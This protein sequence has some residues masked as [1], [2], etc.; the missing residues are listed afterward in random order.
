ML[1]QY[2]NYN[3]MMTVLSAAAAVVTDNHGDSQAVIMARSH[4]HIVGIDLI[5]KLPRLLLER[6]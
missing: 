5:I 6:Y 4:M 1:V 3:E 2:Q